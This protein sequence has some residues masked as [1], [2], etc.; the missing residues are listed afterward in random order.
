MVDMV[1][2]VRGRVEDLLLQVHQALGWCHSRELLL[3]VVV[4]PSQPMYPKKANKM[5]HDVTNIA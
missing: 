3:R 5:K 1:R 2:D 4:P